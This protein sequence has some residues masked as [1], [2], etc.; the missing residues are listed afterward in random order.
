MPQSELNRS[1]AK[2]TGE[3]VGQI[4]RLGFQVEPPNPSEYPHD[5]LEPIDW[6]ALVESRQADPARQGRGKVAFHG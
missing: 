5:P 6:D 1:V 2:A 4:A 3:T